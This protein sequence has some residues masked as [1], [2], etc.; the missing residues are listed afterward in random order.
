M[1]VKKTSDLTRLTGRS[2]A[3]FLPLNPWVSV[4]NLLLSPSGEMYRGS[5]VGHGRIVEHFGFWILD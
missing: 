4:S 3:D 5:G 1:K 2:L